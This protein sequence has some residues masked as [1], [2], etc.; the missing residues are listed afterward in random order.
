VVARRGQELG[1][2]GGGVMEGF[3]LHFEG[4]GGVEVQVDQMGWLRR[5][6]F[7][8]SVRKNIMRVWEEGVPYVGLRGREKLPASRGAAAVLP[9]EVVPLDIEEDLLPLLVRPGTRRI[10]LSFH[11][12]VEGARVGVAI[13][14]GASLPGTDVGVE[15]EDG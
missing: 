1:A 2:V 3:G 14:R 8:G 5:A 11:R 4:A 13:G 6:L 12:V 15:G 7:L 10:C 9:V